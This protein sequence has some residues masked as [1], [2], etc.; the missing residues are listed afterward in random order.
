MIR[1][2]LTLLIL[3]LNLSLSAQQS[4]EKYLIIGTYTSE[5][6]EG[7][8][9]Y[10]FNTETGDN[11]FASSA[12]ASNPSFLTISPDQKY[13]YAVNE[14]ADSTRFTITGHVAAF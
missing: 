11:S 14:N 3:S 13:V 8:Y 10:K 2:V 6:S 5:S 4:K 12:K 9:V 7:I 1:T